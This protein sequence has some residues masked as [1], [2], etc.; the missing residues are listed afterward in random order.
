MQSLPLVGILLTTLSFFLFSLQDASVK[1]LVATLP[2]CQVLFIRSVTIVAICA[3][4]GRGPALRRASGSPV[5]WPMLWR[6]L[7]LLA[8]WLSYYTAARDLGLAQLTTL[9]YAAPIVVTVLAMPVLGE[10]VPPS[11][12]I[13]VLTGFVGVLVACDVFGQGLAVSWPVYLALQAA[14][15]WGIATILLRKTALE[16]GTLVQMLISS[17]L[18]MVFTGLALPFLWQPMSLSELA[19]IVGTGVLAGVGQY[20][21]FEGMRRAEVS[22][23][24][25]FEYSSLIW[26]FLL[27]FLIWHEVPSANVFVGAGLIIGAG[28]LVIGAERSARRAVQS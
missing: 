22:L 3:A 2:V 11:R 12:W 15:F 16:E 24:A 4:I 26:G 5:L 28:V 20:A 10:T 6:T 17:A 27:G 14:V 19:L 8:A 23:L 7:L 25:P 9:Y 13:A 21:L 1:W 18:L